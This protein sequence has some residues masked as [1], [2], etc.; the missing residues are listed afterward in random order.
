[1]MMRR[2]LVALTT[3]A[4]ALIPVACRADA[5]LLSD[6]LQAR[7]AREPGRAAGLGQYVDAIL[8]TALVAGDIA[9]SQNVGIFCVPVEQAFMSHADFRRH[10]DDEIAQEHKDR[11]DFYQYASRVPLAAIGMVVLNKAYPC[12]ADDEGDA[13]DRAGDLRDLLTIPAR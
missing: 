13:K 2:P 3:L 6:Y 11:D 5:M 7:D 10:L 9:R 1:M 8:D 12:N 4:L